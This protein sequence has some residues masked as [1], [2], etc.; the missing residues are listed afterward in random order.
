M[1]LQAG[2]PPDSA[3]ENGSDINLVKY[4]VCNC[5]RTLDT[6]RLQAFP[7][8]K[9][10]QTDV[11]HTVS[12]LSRSASGLSKRTCMSSSKPYPTTAPGITMMTSCHIDN[13][14]QS[15]SE[16]M[17]GLS[18][19]PGG[20]GIK[21]QFLPVHGTLQHVLVLPSSRS[22]S[23]VRTRLFEHGNSTL[24]Q[25]H[26]LGAGRPGQRPNP[27][28]PRIARLPGSP[29][30]GRF[31]GYRSILIPGNRRMTFRI[32]DGDAQDVNLTD[33]HQIEAKS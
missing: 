13:Q 8:R 19:S 2:Q 23:F 18:E 3:L 15:Q 6:E 22:Q 14:K 21:V 20:C 25:P 16:I 24:G 1:A 30:E 4:M 31:K 5:D 32:E 9:P 33:C 12:D 17:W 7:V 27:L 28:G 26:R 29:V 11:I 10:N